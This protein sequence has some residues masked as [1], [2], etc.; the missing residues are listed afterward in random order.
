VPIVNVLPSRGTLMPPSSDEGPLGGPRGST[1]LNHVAVSRLRKSRRAE[2][3]LRNCEEKVQLKQLSRMPESAHI[4]YWTQ[5]QGVRVATPGVESFQGT[6]DLE[7]LSGF[8][9]RGLRPSDADRG[10]SRPENYPRSLN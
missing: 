7:V 9:R 6:S 8:T 5:E 2:G 4:G 3:V 1:C 10:G